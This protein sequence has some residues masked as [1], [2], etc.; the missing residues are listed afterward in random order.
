MNSLTLFA[1]ILFC[2]TY[3]LMFAFQKIRPYVAVLSAVIFVVV[4][5]IGLFPAFS[6]SCVSRCFSRPNLNL[7]ISP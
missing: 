4:G 7:R 1:L 2:V 6:Y 5:S 3:V